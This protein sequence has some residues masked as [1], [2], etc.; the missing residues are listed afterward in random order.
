MRQ[1][2]ATQMRQFDHWVKDI[3]ILNPYSGEWELNERDE[4]DTVELMLAENSSDDELRKKFFEGVREYM[5]D[6]TVSLI[7]VTTG[8]PQ[9]NEL[10]L[11]RFEELFP[12]DVVAVFITLLTRRVEAVDVRSYL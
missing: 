9:E 3:S 6:S 12:I 8:S 11:P 7:A 10:A 4:E 1:S 5:N 2:K